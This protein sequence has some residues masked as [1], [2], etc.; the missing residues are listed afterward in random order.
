MLFYIVSV[1]PV[2]GKLNC[3][4]AFKL[5]NIPRVQRISELFYLIS[6]IVY[7]KLARYIIAGIFKNR[8][9]TV[10]KC[11]AARVAHMHRACRVRAD[12][13]NHNLLALAQIDFSVIRSAFFYVL[14]NL[15][16]PVGGK[17]KV[18]KARSRDLGFC[19]I[20]ILGNVRDYSLRN[21]SG[22][23]AERLC[24]HHRKVARKIA[25]RF[26]LRNL[27][28]YLS[29]DVYI[30]ARKLSRF[31]RRAES[32]GNLFG[33]LCFH[34]VK[35]VHWFIP[36]SQISYALRPRPYRVAVFCLEIPLFLPSMLSSLTFNEF[37]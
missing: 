32:V 33:N 5:L 37:L 25:V 14:H 3:V 21:L 26:V 2:L 8:G 28:L 7:I 35:N 34:I 13:L 36:L 17:I 9:K 12:E 10:A 16:K 23:T 15:I 24:K 11:A 1:I 30:I 18:Y 22:R 4:L 27:K 29:V 6:R 20:F 19:Y 31:N